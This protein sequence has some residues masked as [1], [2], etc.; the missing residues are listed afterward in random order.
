M[1]IMK[2]IIDRIEPEAALTVYEDEYMEALVRN[3]VNGP[4][5]QYRAYVNSKKYVIEFT[6]GKPHPSRIPVAMPQP[7]Q[8]YI[9]VTIPESGRT[10]R[11]HLKWRYLPGPLHWKAFA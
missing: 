7:G 4:A 11:V 1:E 3:R 6:R 8:R 9:Q 5:D 10:Y 2:S